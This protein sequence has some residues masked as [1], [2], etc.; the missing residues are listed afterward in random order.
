[1]DVIYIRQADRWIQFL[2]RG[3]YICKVSYKRIT[4]F[5]WKEWW[6]QS[7]DTSLTINC[8]FGYIIN[9]KQNVIN[10]FTVSKSN[11]QEIVNLIQITAMYIK[12]LFNI[13]VKKVKTETK[14]N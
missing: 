14:N 2:K 5:K 13:C 4:E 12:Q 1:M 3:N 7:T 11:E 9:F 6:I 8:C 10:K